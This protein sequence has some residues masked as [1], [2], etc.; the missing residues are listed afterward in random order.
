MLII[1]ILS[2]WLVWRWARQRYGPR[3]ALIVLLLFV[4][5]PTILAHS[6]YVTT[7][8]AAALGF[9]AGL[10]YFLRWH[11]MPSTSRLIVAGVVFGIAQLLKFSLILLVPLYAILVILFWVTARDR[12]LR[13]FMR[14][15]AG[16]FLIGAIG[17]VLVV[18]P[19]YA[20]HVSGM[21]SSEQVRQS[22]AILE[23]GNVGPVEQLVL[24]SADKT[25]L[26]P[27]SQ[28]L[29]GLSMVYLRTSGG[30][31]TFFMG[32][33]SAEGSPLYF[34]IVFLL[35]EPIPLLLLM[36]CA[37]V[38][39]LG[40]VRRTLGGSVA[41]IRAHH[42]EVS[43]LLFIVVYW[44]ISVM[45]NL[46][47]GVRHVLPTLPFVFLLIGYAVSLLRKTSVIQSVSA[48]LL[49]GAF[50]LWY[51]AESLFTFPFYLSYFNEI[52][53]GPEGGHRYVVDSNL[54][55]G[56]DL[57]RLSE[58]VD[59]HAISSMQLAYFGGDQPSYRLRE[60]YV[61][62]DWS[63][64]S[65]RGWIAVS[66]TLLQGECGKR[67]P[68][69]RGDPASAAILLLCDKKEEA[70]AGYSIFIYRFDE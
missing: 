30:N 57:K 46:N 49:I 53:G 38:I 25:L 58:F 33:T 22:A 23:T 48:S 54:D 68:T 42:D 15:V 40:G 43:W 7:D 9:I 70:R 64:S 67:S 8:S 62:F 2:G 3:T 59:E 44:A 29:L 1:F 31:T 61:P 47:I 32:E 55:W 52:A 17:F 24:W 19:V 56:Q 63:A 18:L 11:K 39:L 37:G 20:F 6:R 60:Q 69:Y 65:H 35:K 21:P 26:R 14:R 27:L 4:L 36:L 12:S 13:E 50:L 41:W 16:A 66:A 10:Y 45:G 51:A 34:P 28:Y 5:S